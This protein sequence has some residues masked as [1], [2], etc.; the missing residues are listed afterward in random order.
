MARLDPC[1]VHAG[2]R[3]LAVYTLPDPADPP[4]SL[5]Q[6]IAESA[7]CR[8]EQFGSG[9]FHQHPLGGAMAVTEHFVQCLANE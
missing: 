1:M 5:G 2:K 7:N 3:V 6:A 4:R 8:R 9:C